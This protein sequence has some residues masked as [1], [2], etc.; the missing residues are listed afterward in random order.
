MPSPRVAFQ[1][2]F[3]TVVLV[4]FAVLLWKANKWISLFLVLAVVSSIYPNGGPVSFTA[5][6]F[7]LYGLFWYFFLVSVLRVKD[8]QPL[9]NANCLKA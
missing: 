3:E 1:L 7:V 6:R 8:I 5:F 4:L 2:F 9:M